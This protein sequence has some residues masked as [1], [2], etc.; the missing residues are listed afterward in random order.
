[1][2]HAI[3]PQANPNF[4]S[5]PITQFGSVRGYVLRLFLQFTF[6][7]KFTSLAEARPLMR[8]RMHTPPVL[9]L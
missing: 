9:I 3:A 6:T 5:M 1:M 8:M 2:R 7:T 4:H